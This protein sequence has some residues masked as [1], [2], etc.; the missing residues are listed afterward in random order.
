MAILELVRPVGKY[1]EQ[2]MQY[3]SEIIADSDN[4]ND[5]EGL[6]DVETFEDWV[7]F[8]D[9]LKA[10]YGSEYVPRELFLG[11]RPEDDKVIGMIVYRHPLLPFLLK[12]GGNIGYNVLPSERGRG[13][14]ADMLNI[15][16]PICRE[17]GEEKIL[18]T[19][20]K[21]NEASRRTILKCGGV[22]E[23]EVEE[24]HAEAYNVSKC[25]IVQRYWINLI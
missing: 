9:R 18:L 14:A 2:I 24:I 22:M 25:G 4:I 21:L 3:K 23:N 1:A 8:E 13:Y 5:C 16:K 20:C 7:N 11:V 6:K 15:L 17:Y 19:C 10:K 12:Y